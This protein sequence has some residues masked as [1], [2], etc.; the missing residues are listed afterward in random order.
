MFY[1]PTALKRHTGCFSTIWLAATKGIKVSRRDYLKVNVKTTCDDIMDYVLVRVPPP[2]PGL[3]R[4]R[5]SLYLSSQLQYGVVVVYHH[6][7]VILLGEIQTTLDRLTKHKPSENINLDDKD[8]LPLCVPDALL[9]L[10]ETEGAQEP[11]FGVMT[12][13]ATMPSPRTLIQMSDRFV[14]S[15]LPEQTQP[16]SRPSTQ[17]SISA[18]PDSITLREKEPVTIP[19]AEFEGLELPDHDLDMIEFLLAQEEH[20]PEGE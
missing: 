12:S 8:G 9:L 5:F 6:Q 11:F 4:P 7:C 17:S 14:D 19:T 20:F 10:T 18:S 15:A 2:Q 13:E 1:Y 3:P 16:P